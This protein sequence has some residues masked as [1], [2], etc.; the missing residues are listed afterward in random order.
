MLQSLGLGRSHK[1]RFASPGFSGTDRSE[2]ERPAGANRGFRESKAV[3]APTHNP[4]YTIQVRAS[5]QATSEIE[6][7]HLAGWRIPEPE[8]RVTVYQQSAARPNRRRR[9]FLQG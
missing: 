2:R 9:F 5:A 4:P 3:E 1:V 7:K 8:A 6:A